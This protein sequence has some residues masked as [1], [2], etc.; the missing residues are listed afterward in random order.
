MTAKL[1]TLTPAAR[2][3]LRDFYDV[4]QQHEA[5]LHAAVLDVIVQLPQMRLLAESIPPEKR[6]AEGAR[7][8]ARVRAAAVDGDWAP[9]LEH[10]RSQGAAYASMGIGFGEWFDLCVVLQRCLG[11]H[12]VAAFVSDPA[13]LTAAVD[14]MNFYV[15]TTMATIGEAYLDTKQK[16]ITE[17]ATSIRELSTPVLEIRDRFLLAPVVGL[18]DD[19]RARALVETLLHAVRAR[20]ARLV[21]I[22]ITGVPGVDSRVANHLLQAVEA[23]RLMGA[24]AVLTGLSSEVA[25]ALVTLGVALDRVIVAGDLRSG[26]ELA[27]EMMGVKIVYPK[28]PVPGTT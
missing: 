25:S 3:G 19:A 23:V 4:M 1:P 22:D 27:N 8:T 11:K 24:T 2:A 20:R 14:G 13:R 6:A 21:L 18:L 12:L 9:L 17:Q 28:A 15:D 10:Q 26:I 7:S 5:E 16:I